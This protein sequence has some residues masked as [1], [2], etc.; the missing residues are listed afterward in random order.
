MRQLFFFPENK[1][2]SILELSKVF[3]LTTEIGSL[4]QWPTSL[5]LKY[6]VRAMVLHLRSPNSRCF[7][8]LCYSFQIIISGLTLSNLF[9]TYKT[10][11]RFPVILRLYTRNMS[12][13]FDP[14]SYNAL[15]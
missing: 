5:T 2:Q 3:D 6:D 15:Q 7:L 10:S 12:K 13:R 9:R 8:L 1:I 14:S 11:I 4:F